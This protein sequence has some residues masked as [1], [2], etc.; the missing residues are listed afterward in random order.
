MSKLCVV[1]GDL[2]QAYL[3]MELKKI[4]YD[5]GALGLEN[6]NL[7]PENLKSKD[8]QS[9]AAADGLLL[10]MPLFKNEAF[11]APF[12]KNSIDLNEVITSFNGKMLF[13]G[14]IPIALNRE[15]KKRFLL[16][17]YLEEETLTCQNAYLT[18]EG[19]VGELLSLLGTS[20]R[21]RHVLIT[22]FGRITKFL[23]H[24]LNPFQVNIVVAARKA[25][26]IEN[27]R[28]LGCEAV[29][30]SDLKGFNGLDAVINTV[31]IKLFPTL[32]LESLTIPYL[33]LAHFESIRNAN[34][35]TY[36]GIPGKKYPLDA[37]KILARYVH[38]KLTEVENE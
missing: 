7:L 16:F 23:I 34:Y 3:A 35:H 29:F 24:F 9:I 20:L 1:G 22:G 12:S 4:G 19:A 38:T 2:R 31:P 15:W 21:N 32:L 33:E 37:G 36:P 6:C 5:I 10:P 25:A 13:A 17:D 14:K 28:L 11:Y 8:K 26:D 27:A 30:L 18:A